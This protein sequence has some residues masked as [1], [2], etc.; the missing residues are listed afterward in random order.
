M[1]MPSNQ[2]VHENNLFAGSQRVFVRRAFPDAVVPTPTW[3]R[4]PK[5]AVSGVDSARRIAS[6]AA[7]QL[8]DDRRE[9]DASGSESRPR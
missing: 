5:A 8:L 6:P 1:P 9:A 7:E 3:Y 2:P 4:A